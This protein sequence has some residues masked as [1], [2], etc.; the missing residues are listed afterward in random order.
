MV[1]P[2]R[3]CLIDVLLNVVAPALDMAGLNFSVDGFLYFQEEIDGGGYHQY[4]ETGI[5]ETCPFTAYVLYDE[6]GV[7]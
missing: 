2:C 3:T 4:A 6:A 1:N 5:K 7:L